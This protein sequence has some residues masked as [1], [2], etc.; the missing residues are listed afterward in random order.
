MHSKPRGLT[1]G[2]QRPGPLGFPPRRSCPWSRCSGLN[3]PPQ[4]FLHLNNRPQFIRLQNT[5]FKKKKEKVLRGFHGK[6]TRKEM[7]GG[8]V[9][10]LQ[11]EEDAVG[12]SSFGTASGLLQ[13]LLRD[14]GCPFAA[15]NSAPEGD[16]KL[17]SCR[18]EKRLQCPTAVP[19]PPKRVQALC[20]SSPRRRRRAL[21]PS[22]GARLCCL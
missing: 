2:K 6:P 14:R 16:A 9:P 20:H 15:T 17:R 10:V 19:T 3:L 1:A 18:K 21:P 8:N 4:L 13:D 22:Q 5:C 7:K 11:D 12:M